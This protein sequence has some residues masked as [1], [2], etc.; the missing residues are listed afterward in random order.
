MKP[1][2]TRLLAMALDGPVT[3]KAVYKTLW[4]PYSPE[5]PDR[6]WALLN[7]LRT[8]QCITHVRYGRWAITERGRIALALAR[9]TP[10][11]IA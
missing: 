6:A 11:R 7:K 9:C 8:H 5:A 1:L 3:F 2:E 10:R 4:P